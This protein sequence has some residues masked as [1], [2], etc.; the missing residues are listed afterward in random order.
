[1]KTEHQEDDR[2]SIMSGEDA[3][4]RG[5]HAGYKYGVCGAGDLVGQAAVS[6]ST[7]Q[8]F[9]RVLAE[10]TAT[11]GPCV[12]WHTERGPVEKCANLS[13]PVAAR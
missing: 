11:L 1:M 10:L 2:Q 7:S 3:D 9:V 4:H 12:A 8:L 6:T 13:V 5:R